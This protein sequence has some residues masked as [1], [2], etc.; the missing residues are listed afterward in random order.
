MCTLAQAH[1]L[2]TNEENIRGNYKCNY[3]RLIVRYLFDES[4]YTRHKCSFQTQMIAESFA[5]LT[6]GFLRVKYDSQR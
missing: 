2:A 3:E 1:A 5:N 6:C 4:G